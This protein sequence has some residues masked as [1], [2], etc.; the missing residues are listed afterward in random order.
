MVFFDDTLVNVH[1]ARAVG[2]PAVHVRTA[3]DVERS[4]IELI[5]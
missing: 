2:M 1:G 4:L 5:G 3:A